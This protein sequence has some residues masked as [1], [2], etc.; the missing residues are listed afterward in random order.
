M[1]IPPGLRMSRNA[2]TVNAAPPN[3]EMILSASPT[4]IVLDPVAGAKALASAS[5]LMLVVKSVVSILI[6]FNCLYT[7]FENNG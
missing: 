2:I 1:L 6:G 7:Y 5:G 3:A 4:L